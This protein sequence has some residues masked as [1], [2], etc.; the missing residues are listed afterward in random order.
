MEYERKRRRLNPRFVALCA[1]V[2]VL[3]LALLGTVVVQVWHSLGGGKPKAGNIPLPDYV[4]PALL[5]PNPYSRPQTPLEQVD[6]LVIH[7]VG[8]P[9]TTAQ[10][11]RDYFESLQAGTDQVFASAH[12]IVGLEGE[13]LQCIPMDEWAYA[14]NQRNADSLGIEVCHPDETGV[15]SQTTY[16]RLVELTAFLCGQ[17]ELEPDKDVIRHYDVS[18]K[19]CPKFY[20]ENEADWEAFLADVAAALPAQTAD[21]KIPA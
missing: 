14:S 6:A 9:G 5:T 13:V 3:A 17:L 10:A 21:N 4:T 18:G 1:V 19:A 12:F 16:D 20:V 15:F 8:N 7:Y 11:N 2:T